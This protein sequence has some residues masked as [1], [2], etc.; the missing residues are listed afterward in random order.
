MQANN[1]YCME[2]DAL[3]N[4]LLALRDEGQASNLKRFFKCGKG[5]YGDG[6]L[7]LGIKV[8]ETRRIVKLHWQNCTFEGLQHLIESP[9]HEV[10]LA[11][12]LTLVTQFKHT[13]NEQEQQQIVAFYLRNIP[14]INNWD[15]VDLSCYEILGRWYFHRD[16][17]VLTE[18]AQSHHTLWERRIAIVST[19]YFVRKGETFFALQ[20]AEMLLDSRED[21]LH[22][23][24]GWVLREIGKHD[25]QALCTFLD[26]HYTSIPRTTLRYAIEKF[27]PTVRQAWL[28]R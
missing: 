4:D 16:R 25:E 22:K 15:L 6:D 17:D 9:F 1:P 28:H 11:A 14:H 24:T 18:L 20:L 12:L 7:F 19:I 27:E 23:A 10:R 26:K 21:L 2:T 8:P 3:Y 13:K 5:E